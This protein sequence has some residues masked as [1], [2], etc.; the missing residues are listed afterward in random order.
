MCGIAGVFDLATDPDE[1][2]RHVTSMLDV[3]SHR[4]PDRA[5]TAAAPG[6]ALGAT[7]LAIVDLE[8]GDQPFT[9]D[10]GI[11]AVYNGEIYNAPELR[12]WLEARG[13]ERIRGGS[14]GAVLPALYAE[15]GADFASALEGMFAI[16]IW[17]GRERR[18]SL[19]RDPFGI[20]PLHVRRGAG[21]LAFASE[22]K[23]LR[24]RFGADPVSMEAIAAYLLW[25]HVPGGKTVHPSIAEVPPGCTWTIDASGVVASERWRPDRGRFDF[26]TMDDA[27]EAIRD[28]LSRSV[29]AQLQSDVPIASFLS[30]GV[31]SSAVATLAAGGVS[32]LSTYCLVFPDVNRA[33]KRLDVDLARAVADRIGSEHHEVPTTSSDFVAGLPAV[34]GAFDQPFAGAISTFYLSAVVGSR[35]KVALTGDGADE[36][37]GS[38]LPH[39]MA[40]WLDAGADPIDEDGFALTRAGMDLATAA[41]SAPALRHGIALSGSPFGVPGLISDH[42]PLPTPIGSDTDSPVGWSRGTHLRAMLDLERRRHL[43]EEVLPFV[44]RL[45]MSHSL[46]LRPPFLTRTM[47]DIAAGL[48]SDRL[49][50]R[51]GVKNVLRRAV[52]PLIPGPV[53]ERGKEGFVQPTIEWLGG[54]LHPWVRETLA[55]DRVAGHGLFIE[56]GI[57]RVVNGLRRE[58]ERYFRIAWILLMLQL[59]WETH[60]GAEVAAP[61]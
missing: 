57:R 47:A 6:C 9:D 20:K 37:F 48:P 10:R 43:A 28:E 32:R 59:W 29:A 14:D 19:A 58:P 4:G 13:H 38:Y 40:A 2:E 31:D 18:L 30:G 61:S 46:E 44:D 34:L 35:F 39:R 51:T 15:L 52:T 54:A 27:A 22:I 5:A 12:R 42:V 16:A 24:G 3:L 56:D 25:G 53:L 1:L 23:A 8:D 33:G 45:S 26:T 41:T 21:S 50:D 11:L 60:V 17:D 49:I 7:R 55:P 36:L